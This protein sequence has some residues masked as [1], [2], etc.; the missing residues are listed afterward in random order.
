[1]DGR[2]DTATD[3]MKRILWLTL[4]LSAMACVSVRD[5]ALKEDRRT[6][7]V[8]YSGGEAVVVD[9]AMGAI[10]KATIGSGYFQYISTKD[11]TQRLVTDSM[12]CVW[13]PLQ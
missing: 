7:V 5:A 4:C 13:R 3:M 8:C 1:M 12:A 6:E 9:T 11:S 2:G 10:K